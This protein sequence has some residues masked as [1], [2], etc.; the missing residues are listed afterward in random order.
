[1]DSAPE[2][3]F[4]FEGFQLDRAGACLFRENGTGSAEPLTLGSRAIALLGLLLDRQGKLVTKDEIFAAVWRG[5]CRA[6]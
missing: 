1:M 3:V 4:R 6:R 5:T 2:E